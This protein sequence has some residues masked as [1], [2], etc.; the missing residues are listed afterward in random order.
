M[1]ST[2]KYAR[3]YA[4]RHAND[5]ESKTPGERSAAWAGGPRADSQY[6]IPVWCQCVSATVHR[7]F[8]LGVLLGAVAGW[9]EI[10]EECDT[11]EM[12]EV[13]RERVMRAIIDHP[14]LDQES[15][16]FTSFS[17]S[18]VP[19]STR[20]TQHPMQTGHGALPLELLEEV[21]L[22]LSPGEIPPL[23]LVNISPLAHPGSQSFDQDPPASSIT[24]FASS[25]T[26]RP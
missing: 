5:P 16:T 9:N 6:H 3:C 15:K 13:V 19:H 22:W 20:L 2:I 23:R 24:G 25:S 8:E 10:N 14:L 12:V 26:T 21:I 4:T 17:Y 1:K 11:S 18:T 7:S